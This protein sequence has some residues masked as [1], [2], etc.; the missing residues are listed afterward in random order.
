MIT[1]NT[2]SSYGVSIR[3]LDSPYEIP[4]SPRAAGPHGR[5]NHIVP[6]LSGAIS[7]STG[8]KEKEEATSAWIQSLP[9]SSENQQIKKDDDGEESLGYNETPSE[10]SGLGDAPHIVPDIS[11]SYSIYAASTFL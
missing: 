8:E 4:G 3:D 10:F 7:G 5:K 1:P 11:D 2:G 6:A 9:Q